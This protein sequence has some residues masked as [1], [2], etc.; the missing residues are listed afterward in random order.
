MVGGVT[1]SASLPSGERPCEQAWGPD[2]D[3]RTK[4]LVAVEAEGSPSGA[5]S[6][7]GGV[8]P[9][10]PLAPPSRSRQFIAQIPTLAAES[11]HRF[12][13]GQVPADAVEAISRWR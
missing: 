3:R 1:F 4:G 10:R 7:S 8:D 5:C 9:V 11:L 6:Q 2:A 13:S 12:R